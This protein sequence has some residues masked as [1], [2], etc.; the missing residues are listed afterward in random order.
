MCSGG[1]CVLRKL[2]FSLD[3]FFLCV[4]N[5][6]WNMNN[7]LYVIL[8][9]L[10]CL[11]NA[12][13]PTGTLFSHAFHSFFS[14]LGCCCCIP[15]SNDYKA[16]L[17]FFRSTP[18]YTHHIFPVFLSEWCYIIKK[19][20]IQYFTS[21]FFFFFVCWLVSLFPKLT[22]LSLFFMLLLLW[23]FSCVI[24]VA[25]S[26]LYQ[27]R[28]KFIIVVNVWFN[29]VVSLVGFYYFLFLFF[30]FFFNMLPW[31]CLSFICRHILRSN[32]CCSI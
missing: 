28:K 18:L 16:L 6:A 7:V 14:F 21:M 8:S 11:F 31:F 24:V 4:R 23:V 32:V 17:S 19:W 25:I 29:A 26:S 27:N 9:F 13:L 2:N 10:S 22:R 20:T 3:F 5:Q 1:V 30:F 12:S 15:P